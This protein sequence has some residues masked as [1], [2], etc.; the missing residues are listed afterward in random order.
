MSTDPS[1]S[2]GLGL[3]KIPKG[4][5]LKGKEKEQFEAKAE[6][7]Y[8]AGASIRD[9]SEESGR[10]FATV[11]KALRARKVPLRP[12]GGNNHPQQADATPP[13]ST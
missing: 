6:A 9:I 3:P 11:N 12:R 1:A 13:E 4:K 10:A 8:R 5:Q 7:A 2:G